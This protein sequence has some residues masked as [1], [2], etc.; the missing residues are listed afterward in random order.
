MRFIIDS[1]TLVAADETQLRGAFAKMRGRAPANWLRPNAPTKVARDWS[2]LRRMASADVVDILAL[3][4]PTHC[5]DG[6]GYASRAMTALLAGDLHAARHLAYYAQLRGALSMLANL[7]IGIFN[8]VNF[9]VDSRGQIR[10]LDT[11]QSGR[12]PDKGMGTHVAVWKALEA[13]SNS[14]QSRK[15]LV[16]TRLKGFSLDAC[17]DQL[18]TGYSAT[19]VVAPL[20]E[21]WGLDLARGSQDHIA[22]NISSY[23]PQAFNPMPDQIGEVLEFLADMW[24]SLEPSGAGGFDNLDRFFLRQLFQQQHRIVTQNQLYET[25]AI[26][27]KFDDLPAPI[28][29]MAPR[30]FLLGKVSPTAPALLRRARARGQAPSPMDML[31][32]AI[33]L[34]RVASAFTH[35]NLASSGIV[36]ASGELRPWLDQLAIDR[37]FWPPAA[38]AS[39]PIELWDD[40]DQA[41][42]SVQAINPLPADLCS[43]DAMPSRWPAGLHLAQ[44]ERA[45]IWTFAA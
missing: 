41:V 12:L 42:N 22:R 13:W 3:S 34:L 28:R 4:A 39:D 10:R 5:V 21:A 14:I 43:W 16:L 32:R 6:W 19:A 15:F 33:I 27:T 30:N 11:V 24:T 2:A 38:P 20:I 8:Q 25:G 31:S 17:L 29:S 37:G 23:E 40:L 36:F 7:G 44:A 1:A 35:T 9:V 26:G 45:G 18:W